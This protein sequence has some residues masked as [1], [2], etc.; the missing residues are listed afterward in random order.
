MHDACRTARSGMRSLVG[1]RAPNQVRAVGMHAPSQRPHMAQAPEFGTLDVTDF[2][3][4]AMLRAGIAVRRAVRGAASTEDAAEAVV[5]Y[6]YD[7]CATPDGERSALM[8]RFYKT[9]PY[10]TL[11][12]A[13]RQFA[14]AQLGS[15]HP[16]DDMRCLVL[17][18]TV[19]EE[20]EWNS[21]HDSKGHQAIPLPSAERVRAAPMIMR[22]I[23]E[24]G[25]DVESLVSSAP[26]RARGSE[27]RTYDVFHVEDAAGSPYIPAQADFVER[28]GVASVVGFGGMLRSGELFAVILFSRHRIPGRSASRFRT[29]AL[30]VRSSLFTL[31]DSRTWREGGVAAGEP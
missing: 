19:G 17:M 28:Y 27:T 25:V 8:V 24:L 20:P 22:L 21:R 14:A 16:R 12:P 1:S 7:A 4:G 15:A 26:E 30:D 5:R 13:L 3:V 2:T 29:I 18:A 31:D 11:E 6:L 23:E 9:H 10:G